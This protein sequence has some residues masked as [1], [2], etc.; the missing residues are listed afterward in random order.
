ME[1]DQEIDD[2][3][4]VG[5]SGLLF[6]DLKIIPSPMVPIVLESWVTY[7]CT[8]LLIGLK[9]HRLENTALFR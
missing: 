3:I 4:P 6:K 7:L 9:C 1:G 2:P 5:E 8:D